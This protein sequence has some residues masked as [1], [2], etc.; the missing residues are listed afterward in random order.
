MINTFF[1]GMKMSNNREYYGYVY[2]WTNN[3]NGKKYIGSHG[4][5]VEDSYTGSNKI[6]QQAYKKRPHAFS[7]K[8]LEYVYEHSQCYLLEREQYWLNN[9]DN[10]KDNPLYYNLKNEANGGWSHIT[11]IHIETRAETLKNRQN[12]DGLTEAEKL[13]YVEKQK[14]RKNRW[15]KEGFSTK[16]KE[17]HAS[18]GVTVKVITPSGEQKIFESYSQ[19]TRECGIDIQ[20]CCIVTEKKG[21]YKGFK[22][23]K[24]SDPKIDCRTFKKS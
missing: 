24:V 8:V 11:N 13:S 12:K 9:I 4:G 23:Y 21:E 15:K 5:A 18:Y 16:E 6:F 22:A 19:A 17:Q 7:M 20:Y 3:I 14:T 10:I 1:R 2:E